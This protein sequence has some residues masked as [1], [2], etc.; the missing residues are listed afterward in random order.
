MNAVEAIRMSPITGNQLFMEQQLTR[1]TYN[2]VARILAKYNI[3]WDKKTKS[4]IIPEEYSEEFKIA[5]QQGFTERK[6]SIQQEIGFFQTPQTLAEDLFLYGPSALGLRVLEP[7]GGHGRIITAALNNNAGE[8]VTVEKYGPNVDVLRENFFHLENVHIHQGDFLDMTA[9]DLG[10][11]FDAVVANPPFANSADITH[12]L[13]AAQMVKDGGFIT[14]IMSAGVATNT[15]KKHKD[16]RAM[17]KTYNGIIEPLPKG[18]FKSE[19]TQV[20]TV[21]AHFIKPDKA[22]IARGDFWEFCQ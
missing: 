10:G 13:H 1:D 9:D 11:L 17:V 7:N 18:T 14:S 8:I 21:V 3:K 16:F 12:I 6:K 15:N 22:D 20:E 5:L 4:H 2:Q 19:G